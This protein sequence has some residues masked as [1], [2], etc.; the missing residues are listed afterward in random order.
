[1]DEF[2]LG[3]DLSNNVTT[4]VSG[5]TDEFSE[6]VELLLEHRASPTE[7]NAWLAYCFGAES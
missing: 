6:L 5:I 1:L 7:Q 2:F 4:L 3:L